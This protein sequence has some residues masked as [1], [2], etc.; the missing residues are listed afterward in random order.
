MNN[1]RNSLTIRE[2]EAGVIMLTPRS[3]PDP[4]PSL[5]QSI[6]A[7]SAVANRIA[8][9]LIAARRLNVQLVRALQDIVE[10]PDSGESA[11]LIAAR[12]LNGGGE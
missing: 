10:D 7:F 12:A 8:D 2:V 9:Q 1:D 6:D 3:Q 4:I 11:M 5:E